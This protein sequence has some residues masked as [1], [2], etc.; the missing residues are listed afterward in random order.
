[1]GG[2]VIAG[3]FVFAQADAAALGIVDVVVFG[4]PPLAPVG[5]N[6]TGLVTGGR[7]PGTGGVGHLKATNG[8]VVHAAGFG[9]EAALS[10]I[11][12]NKLPVGIIVLEIAKQGGGISIH[13][14]VPAIY[15][16]LGMEYILCVEFP[17]V[18]CNDVLSGDFT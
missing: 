3:G 6:Q 13:L 18:F 5:A 7:C 16:Q 17:E 4:D 15:G 10:Y 2:K 14:R 12:L 1:M 8:D 9:I 11:D